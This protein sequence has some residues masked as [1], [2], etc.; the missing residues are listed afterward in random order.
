M[1]FLILNPDGRKLSAFQQSGLITTVE[2]YTTRQFIPLKFDLIRTSSKKP[3]WPN[4]LK[5]MLMINKL[6]VLVC[7]VNDSVVEFYKM[8]SAITFKRYLK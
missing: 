7:F 8:Q 1:K 5:G 6:V 4:S 3:K 2:R